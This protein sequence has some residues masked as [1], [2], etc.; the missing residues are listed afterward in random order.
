MDN[1]N[2][3]RGNYLGPLYLTDDTRIGVGF[4]PTPRDGDPFPVNPK[5]PGFGSHT[6]FAF[7]RQGMTIGEYIAAGGRRSDVAFDLVRRIVKVLD[8]KTDM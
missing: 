3:P 8:L 2:F 4:G 7:Y 6:R 5:Q 1:P